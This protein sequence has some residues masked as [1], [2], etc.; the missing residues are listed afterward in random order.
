MDGRADVWAFGCVLYEML[1]GSQAFHGDE[2]ADILAAVLAKEPNANAL[3]VKL[4]PR[5]RGLLER[6]LEKQ[7]RNRYH[8]IT[9]ARVDIEKALADPSGVL[10]KPVAEV[11]QVARQ[12]KLPWL[13][14]VSGILVVGVAVWIL[15]PP[16]P[17]TVSRFYHV[18]PDT[19]QFTNTRRPLVTISPDGF[20]FVYVANQQLHVRAID[21]LE[22]GPIPGTDDIVSA[23]F[24]SPD[25]QSVGYFSAVDNELKRI[26]VAGGVPVKLADAV[27]P[28]GIPF[29]GPDDTVV[30]GQPDGIMSVSASGGVPQLLVAGA[31]LVSPQ[32]LPDGR[33]LLFST[34]LDSVGEVIVQSLDSDER[35]VLFAGSTPKYV[36]TGH[37]VFALEEGLFAIPFDLESWEVAGGPVP[38]IDGVAQH[39]A[40][41]ATGTLVYVP[42]SATVSERTL[43]LVNKDGTVEP[44]NVPPNQYLSPRISP[45][46]RRLAVQTDNVNGSDIWVYDLSGETQIRQLTEGGSNTSP[47]WTPDDERLVFGSDRDGTM[48]V[49]WQLADGSRAAERLTY[50][51]E[52][53]EDRP[54]SWSPD[55]STLAFTR[56]RP[57]LSIWTLSLDGGTEPTL[58][59]D[60]LGSDQ[61]SAEFSPNGN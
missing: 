19:H 22:S 4:H 52:G 54:G 11:A 12:S 27:E 38:L 16:D 33:T 51:E 29:W 43:A 41:S 49:Y 59:Y 61:S 8:G 2:V 58:L 10:V 39:S 45:D 9:D 40:I 50:A 31:G 26:A 3:P 34:G 14:A 57:D 7:S 1:T 21:S 30:F 6:C 48:S 32:V 55:G 36:S 18:L 28:N 42:G 37:I 46:G 35:R 5:I 13:V 47:I 25:G 53:S 44:L 24:F 60:V 56:S 23:P 15:K 17:G 20:R